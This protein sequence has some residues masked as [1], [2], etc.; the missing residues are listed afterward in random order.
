MNLYFKM[1]FNLGNQTLSEPLTLQMSA[2]S[3]MKKLFKKE[4]EPQNFAAKF[5]NFIRI[6][7]FL[8][9]SGNHRTQQRWTGIFM[10]SL[11]IPLLAQLKDD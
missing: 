4:S 3:A 1:A 9:N 11:I 7:S 5:L 8:K 10:N 6:Y 2:R